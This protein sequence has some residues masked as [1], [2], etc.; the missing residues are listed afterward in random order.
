[1]LAAAGLA[2]MFLL[3]VDSPVQTTPS[4]L[5]AI[6][7][8]GFV[9]C[10]VEPTVPGFVE[11][12]GQ[13]AYRGLDVDICRAVATAIFGMPD[14]LRFVRVAHVAELSTKGGPARIQSGRRGSV[15]EISCD[16]VGGMLTC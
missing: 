13:G 10:G 15:R 2:T 8:R 1:M 12:D 16:T 5:T 3:G 9:T 7:R 11:V 14:R 4:R 6:E